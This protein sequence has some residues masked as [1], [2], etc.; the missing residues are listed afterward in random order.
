MVPALAQS[1]RGEAQV[2]AVSPFA[3]LSEDKSLGYIGF[4][5][6]EFMTAMFSELEGY[7]VVER[8]DLKKVF[9]EQKMQLL[10]LTDEEN[11]VELGNIL[12]ATRILAGSYMVENGRLT[13]YGRVVDVET[14]EVTMSS[15][16][17][18]LIERGSERAFAQL[19]LRLIGRDS[20]QQIVSRVEGDGWD[21][22]S[23]KAKR[24][25]LLSDLRESSRSSNI[26]A[27]LA[28]IQ[29]RGREAAEQMAKALEADFGRNDEESLS[30][31]E[32]VVQRVEDNPLGFAD[33]ADSYYEKY[34]Q[35]QGKTLYSDLLKQQLE[36]NKELSVQSEELTLYRNKLKILTDGIYAILEPGMFTIGQEREAEIELDGLSAVVS[37]PE[38][39]EIRTRDFVRDVLGELISGQDLLRHDGKEIEFAAGE[40]PQVGTLL[41][42]AEAIE[43]LFSF[44]LQAGA[45]V[46]V[47]F[48][49]A[50]GKILYA[51]DSKTVFDIFSFS[52]G[53][54]LRF[55]HTLK[56]PEYRVREEKAGWQFEGGSIRILPQA[57]KKVASVRTVINR[58]AFDMERYFPMY[59]NRRWKSLLLHAFRI[60]YSPVGEEERSFPEVKNITL[61]NSSF[62]VGSVFG[63]SERS[64]IPLVGEDNRL[65]TG[66]DIQATLYWGAESDAVLSAE[67]RGAVEKE[68][69]A[70]TYELVDGSVLTFSAP[71][72]AGS[73]SFTLIG[74]GGR[75]EK[76]VSWTVESSGGTRVQRKEGKE[77]TD[78]LRLLRDRVGSDRYVVKAQNGVLRS[79][80][81]HTGETIWQKSLSG[82]RN[83]FVSDGY[84]GVLKKGLSVEVFDLLSGK[85]LYVFDDFIGESK[86]QEG[87]NMERSRRAAESASL[88]DMEVTEDYIVWYCSRHTYINCFSVLDR[89]SGELST[90]PALP[91]IDSLHAQEDTLLYTR[92]SSGGVPYLYGLDL[93]TGTMLIDELYFRGDDAFLFRGSDLWAMDGSRIY[94]TSLSLLKKGKAPDHRKQNAQEWTVR[95]D[96]RGVIREARLFH[97]E[98]MLYVLV[99]GRYLSCYD[100]AT[101]EHLWDLPYNIGKVDLHFSGTTLRLSR[102][103]YRL[104]DMGPD[105]MKS[106]LAAGEVLDTGVVCLEAS[107]DEKTGE[108]SMFRKFEVE[109]GRYAKIGE[110]LWEDG[111]YI[112]PTFAYGG[113]GSGYVQLIP[114]GHP[115]ILPAARAHTIY[116]ELLF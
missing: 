90:Y 46:S 19:F 77:K 32:T 4:Q 71:A 94:K 108:V 31:L 10:G 52:P 87:L 44:T 53:N 116:E 72:R 20:L 83:S 95:L 17:S 39:V 85:N 15:R 55:V 8:R 54:E 49:D 101:G 28:L 57:L 70:T 89:G 86:V 26:E 14:G 97:H 79:E 2:L 43:T 110:E 98:N 100:A 47:E 82:S 12:N 69:E 96:G 113:D 38:G 78:Y 23:D 9:E 104:G 106:A 61:S 21:A 92:E 102:I 7:R 48:L 67:W 99:Q 105:Q 73:G 91:D 64:W 33:A 29:S 84:V 76:S 115:G 37:L 93:R 111:A 25:Q 11:A 63:D 58:D 24:R 5:I 74:K 50:D 27:R 60:A 40:K 13:I 3:N 66:A 65:D 103:F 41:P 1:G 34:S 51:L 109:P 59:S 68:V 56:H 45:G 112:V 35:V 16:S 30:Y 62:R 88:L 18:G 80:R 6:Y 36:R 107:V 114:G 75:K 22:K 42:E 81:T